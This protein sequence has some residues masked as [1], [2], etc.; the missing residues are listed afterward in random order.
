[1]ATINEPSTSR[2]IPG[3][4]MT[5][6]LGARPW[7][8]PYQYT[9]LEEALDYYIPRLSSEEVRRKLFD[10]LEMGI[11]V[12]SVANSI[13]LSSVMEGKHS[14]DIG[15]LILPILMEFIMLM[16]DEVGIKY[17]NGMKKDKSIRES[18]IDLAIS[19]LEEAGVTGL[20]FDK[21]EKEEPVEEEE[22]KGLMARRK[23]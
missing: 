10:V 6:E 12:T 9:T 2:P 13:Q 22:T 15:M 11:P 20:D 8:T 7:Q 5:H 23:A 16:A 4:G 21:E 17:D 19:K 3:M 14:V 18:S 1:M